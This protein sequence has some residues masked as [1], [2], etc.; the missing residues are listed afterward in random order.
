MTYPNIAAERAR[1]GITQE[2]LA[3]ELRVC[4]KTLWNWE[5][6]GNIPMNKVEAMAKLFGVTSDYLLGHNQE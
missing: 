2:Q 6:N 1:K 5:H 4:R 3:K